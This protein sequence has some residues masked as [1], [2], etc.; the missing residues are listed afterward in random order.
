MK[1]PQIIEASIEGAAEGLTPFTDGPEPALSSRF[2]QAGGLHSLR[3]TRRTQ[4]PRSPKTFLPPSARGGRR[5]PQAIISSASC[6]GGVT[7]RGFKQ[8]RLRC[9][10]AGWGWHLILSYR[11]ASKW[12]KLRLEQSFCF[13]PGGCLMG[14]ALG[15]TTK[16][17]T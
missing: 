14:K 4:T 16:P 8:T 3:K 10:H 13:S 15:S 12:R 9:P 5:W 7:F 11:K 2:R 17:D 1:E 6:A